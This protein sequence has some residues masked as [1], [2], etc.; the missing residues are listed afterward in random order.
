M[1]QA[2]GTRTWHWARGHGA[3]SHTAP[4]T[5]QKGSIA[6][7]RFQ[8]RSQDNPGLSRAQVWDG[9]RLV[10]NKKRDSLLELD[11]EA[12]GLLFKDTSPITRLGTL[13]T[14]LPK[15]GDPVGS[16][17]W[18]GDTDAQCA[19][20]TRGSPVLRGWKVPPRVAT[21]DSR[22]R[23]MRAVTWGHSET[24]VSGRRCRQI[25]A[26]APEGG[27]PGGQSG[28]DHE[29]PVTLSSTPGTRKGFRKEGV[30]LLGTSVCS[31]RTLLTPS[32]GL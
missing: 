18:W 24:R 20:P 28:V 1:V 32:A 2:R 25:T 9:G 30:W 31:H 22:K 21:R 8:L 27:G 10:G 4:N 23:A 19:A 15:A 3:P 11:T 14:H 26:A 6:M 16:G 12:L 29:G 17:G 5:G 13:P 7:S